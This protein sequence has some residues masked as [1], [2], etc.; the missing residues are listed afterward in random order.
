MIFANQKSSKEK[1][2]EILL[3]RTIKEK[4]ENMNLNQ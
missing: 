4:R 2:V 3:R 1:K